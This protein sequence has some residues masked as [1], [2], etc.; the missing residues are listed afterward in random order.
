MGDENQCVLDCG[1]G[2]VL[3]SVGGG[4]EDNSCQKNKLNCLF[5]APRGPSFTNYHGKGHLKVKISKCLIYL[6]KKIV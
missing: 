4:L 5:F 3:C 2:L 6:S 1:G